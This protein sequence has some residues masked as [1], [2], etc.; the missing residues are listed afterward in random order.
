VSAPRRD[1]SA[2]LALVVV[3]HD[4]AVELQRLLDSVATHLPVRPQVVVVDNA[5]GDGGG[6]LA[7]EWGADVVAM[8]ANAGFGAANNAGLALVGAP[9]TALVNPDVELLDDGLLR[10]ADVATAHNALIAPR[11]LN[12]DASLQRSAHPRPGTLESLLPALLPPALMT[13]A[14]RL[15]ADPS[16]ATRPRRVGWAIGACLVAPT[17][18]LRRLGPFVPELFLFYEDLDLCLRAAAAGVATE[19]H[20][21]VRLR[22]AGA[23][24]TARAYGGEPHEQMARRRREVVERDLGP[25]ALRIDDAAQAITFATRALARRALGR[26]ARREAAQLRALLAARR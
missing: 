21:G 18:V 15:R 8:P 1:R 3:I 22:H 10:L 11:L 5:S 19:L 6:E 2:G 13:P 7:R 24:S 14:L 26:D 20:P 16:R 23:H 12:S 4:S 17:A 9:V 25:M